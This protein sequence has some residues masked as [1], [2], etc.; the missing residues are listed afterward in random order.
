MSDEQAQPIR[1]SIETANAIISL[2]QNITGISA[3]T[4]ILSHIRRTPFG[5]VVSTKPAGILVAYIDAR[6]EQRTFYIVIQENCYGHNYKHII[7]TGSCNASDKLDANVQN[8]EKL[9]DTELTNLCYKWA[10]EALNVFIRDTNNC[11]ASSYE[12]IEFY[13]SCIQ[14]SNNKV[15]TRKILGGIWTEDDVKKSNKL[16]YE[17]INES[18]RIIERDEARIAKA[19]AILAT[20]KH[21]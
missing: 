11:I 16:D 13:R 15:G 5:L 17:H 20:L 12:R 21:I 8:P 10:I 9:L 1:V 14:K 19:D 6:N 4:G 2:L 7:A 3:K 18:L